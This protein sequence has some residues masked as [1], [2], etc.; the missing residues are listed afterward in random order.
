M[1]Y[2][3]RKEDDKI[4]YYY[5]YIY[6]ERQWCILSYLQKRSLSGKTGSLCRFSIRN[7]PRKSLASTPRQF[8]GVSMG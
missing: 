2:K 7:F 6:R 4:I 8:V 3:N 5:L 1:V